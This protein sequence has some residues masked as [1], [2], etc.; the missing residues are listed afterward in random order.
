MTIMGIR[1]RHIQAQIIHITEK[2]IPSHIIHTATILD[3]PLIIMVLLTEL[4]G[5]LTLDI[6]IMGDTTIHIILNLAHQI[7]TQEAIQAMEIVTC[8]TNTLHLDN[9]N[10]IHQ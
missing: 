10:A 2:V 5:A 3:I 7:I 8:I 1:L 4:T 9:L 6:I